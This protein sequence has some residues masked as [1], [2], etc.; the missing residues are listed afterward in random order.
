LPEKIIKTGCQEIK[1]VQGK[2][3]S[4]IKLNDDTPAQGFAIS[5]FGNPLKSSSLTKGFTKKIGDSI[6]SEAKKIFQKNKVANALISK[7]EM[8]QSYTFS[9]P[10]KSTK[11]AFVRYAIKKDNMEIHNVYIL[12]QVKNDALGKIISSKFQSIEGDMLGYGGE[13]YLTGVL[14]LEENQILIFH[15]NGF[16]GYI[17]GVYQLDENGM[18]EL[19]L[20][21]G[22]A[23]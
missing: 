14:L 22:D 21:G 20:G 11:F 6:S 13:F 17:N 5:N 1:V 8:D 18:T 4:T 2:L 12:A 15:H 9:N 23:C 19:A 3:K 16:D 7:M 10:Y